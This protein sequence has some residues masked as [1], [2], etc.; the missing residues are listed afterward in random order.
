MTMKRTL[1]CI[2]A[3]AAASVA[4]AKVELGANVRGL[5]LVDVKANLHTE[6]YPLAHLVCVGPKSCVDKGKN[7][8]LREVF[9]PW[10]SCKATDIELKDVT[11]EDDVSAEA[12]HATVFEDVN[13]DGH[14]T[15]KGEISRINR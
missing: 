6:K 1:F 7:G 12:V 9:D 13:G 5:H 10:V 4:E 15:G 8:R 3:A 14:S 2:L 11:Y